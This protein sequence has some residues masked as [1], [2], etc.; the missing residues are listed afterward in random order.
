MHAGRLFHDKKEISRCD[1]CGSR[2]TVPPGVYYRGR[3][4]H[5]KEAERMRRQDWD[6]EVK[7]PDLTNI[8]Q[9]LQSS[10]TNPAGT[11]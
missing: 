11:P 4:M 8:E 3:V 10:L 9:E 2:L 6:V 1:I 5:L 7:A